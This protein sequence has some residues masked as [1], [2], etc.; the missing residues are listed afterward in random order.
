M[1]AVVT[2]VTIRGA[3][4]DEGRKEGRSDDD[5]DQDD[6]DLFPLFSSPLFITRAGLC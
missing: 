5:D 2:Q 3:N 4:K 6:V 1:V